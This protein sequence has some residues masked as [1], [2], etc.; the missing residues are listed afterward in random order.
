MHEGATTQSIIDSTL[1]SLE[2][3]DLA[4]KVIAVCVTIGVTQG[5]VPE[6]MQMFF[7]MQTYDTPLE[8]A[9]LEVTLQGIV[10]QCESCAKEFELDEAYMICPECQ[11]PLL[12]IKG[13]ELLLTS[14]EVET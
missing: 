3:H 14:I 9:R 5:M 11:G 12:M 8:G 2:E 13:K 4:G 10:G 1:A 6:A 7:E